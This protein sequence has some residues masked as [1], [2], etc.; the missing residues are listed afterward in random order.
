MSAV[1][2]ILPNLNTPI[3]FLEERV[4]SIVSQTWTDWECIIVDGY[5]DNGSWEYLQKIAAKD[6]RFK[7]YQ[8]KKE[9]IYKAWNSGIELAK[10]EFIYIATSDD[11]MTDNCLEELVKALNKEI[12]CGIAH[13]SLTIID[14]NGKPH[15]V[16]KWDRFLPSVYF[17]EL[18]K[19][20]H[21]RIAPHDG[22]LHCGI[23]TVY[24]SIVQLLIRK[25][26][27]K[28]VGLFLTDQGSIADF[29][30]EMRASLAANTVHVP[31]Y[32]ASWRI[33]AL[34]ATTD[35]IQTTPATYEKLRELVDRAFEASIREGLLDR[36]W[37]RG[38]LKDI[39]WKNEYDWAINASKNKIGTFLKYFGRHPLLLLK[40]V[41]L[42][43]IY[44]GRYD[45]LRFIRSKL[46]KLGL[47]KSIRVI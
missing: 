7:A 36:K 37:K 38:D 2:I 44:R 27:F 10:G 13:C 1:S 14:E 5:S 19:K 31:L 42:N 16:K 12:E 39:Y 34:Q 45:N 30:W 8:F 40:L 46:K 3:P 26:L 23:K 35:T 29:E 24:T 4:R 28:K 33:H 17:G 43:I 20:P 15:P 22:I 6:E 9:G 41:S 32:L 11:T 47:D 18:M 25:S 21:I